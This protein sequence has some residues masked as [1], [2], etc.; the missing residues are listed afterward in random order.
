VASVVV[1]TFGRPE[2]LRRCVAA[3]LGQTLADIEVVISDDGGEPAA[4]ETLASVDDARL[5]I[6]RYP[7][8]G[9]AAARNRGAAEARAELLAFTDDDCSPRPDWLSRL[10]DAWLI[11]PEDMVGGW[12]V[13]ALPRNAFSAASQAVVDHLY[14]VLNA[15]P[16]DARFLTSNNIAVAR[17]AFLA[18]GGFDASYP[19]AAGEDREWCRRWRASGRRIRLVP[20]A[21]IDHHHCLSARS[22]WRQHA[23]YGRGARLFRDTAA[24]NDDGRF[25]FP[26]DHLRLIARPLP[27]RPSVA[28]LLAIAQVA[29][30]AGSRSGPR[31]SSSEKVTD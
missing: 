31:A 4:A 9:P 23:N 19:L 26:I 21:V 8:A 1:P 16:S 2:G 17:E 12:T 18:L 22:F 30:A 27:R 10:R 13:N 20:E 7:N 29:T 11:S 6:V 15:D 14:D 5:R 24:G 28:A 3:L 25:R